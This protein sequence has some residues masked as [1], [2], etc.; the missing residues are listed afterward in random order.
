MKQADQDD[1]LI[2]LD[3]PSGNFLRQWIRIYQA[4]DKYSLHCPPRETNLLHIAS[5]Y[6]L[7]ST[8]LVIL[9]NLDKADI[10]V[11]SKNIDGRT[12]LSYAAEQGHVDV[13]ELLL[14]RSDVDAELKD[15]Y[16]WT[17]L[18]WA[19][20][21]GH[22]SVMGMLLEKGDDIETKDRGGG[23]PL[24]CAIDSGAEAVVKLVLTKSTKVDFWFH[25]FVSKL[26]LA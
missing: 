7:M 15:N 21:K 23:T 22:E 12:P 24:I 25:P 26:Y 6:G 17:A 14:A 11:D 9:K 5:R 18:H 8:L 19:A 3:W 1:L 2:Y 20:A 10:T 13:V 16:G 4:I